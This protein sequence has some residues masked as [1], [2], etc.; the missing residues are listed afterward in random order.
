[1]DII[2][3]DITCHND[4]DN[5]QTLCFTSGKHTIFQHQFSYQH[6]LKPRTELVIFNEVYQWYVL[7]P[8]QADT[9]ILLI[10][11]GSSAVSLTSVL[12]F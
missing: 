3:A 4:V 12:L 2:S 11:F 8:V 6:N 5:S 9:L 10:N 1:M 7:K